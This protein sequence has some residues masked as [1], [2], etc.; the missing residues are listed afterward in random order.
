VDAEPHIVLV[1]DDHVDRTA[2]LRQAQSW[3]MPM[4]NTGSP[5]SWPRPC[6]EG[7]PVPWLTPCVDG[8]AEWADA[9]EHRVAHCRNHWLCQVCGETLGTTAWVVLEYG[10]LIVSGAA[11]HRRYLAGRS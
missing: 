9:L 2:F 11:L 7:L 8:V 1:G 10:D 5:A 6:V 3:G 4:D